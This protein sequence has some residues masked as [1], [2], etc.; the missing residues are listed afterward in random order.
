MNHGARRLL[1]LRVFRAVDQVQSQAGEV[2]HIARENWRLVI[3][4]AHSNPAIVR[5]GSTAQGQPV[6][7]RLRMTPAR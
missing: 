7:F 2:A 3:P 4:A 1:N 5:V 6:L